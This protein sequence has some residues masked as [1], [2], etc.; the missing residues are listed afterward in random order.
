M[1]VWKITKYFYLVFVD[2]HLDD[3]DFNIIYW[4][5]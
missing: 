4:S 2:F 5:I 1:F 3:I